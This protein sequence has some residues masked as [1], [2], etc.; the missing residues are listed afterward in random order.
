MAD[1]RAITVPGVDDSEIDPKLRVAHWDAIA[2]LDAGW[3]LR[4]LRYVPITGAGIV[5]ALTPTHRAVS[6]CSTDRNHGVHLL[7]IHIAKRLAAALADFGQANQHDHI[8]DLAW[9]VSR[10]PNA[11]ARPALP[12][13][14]DPIPDDKL[15]RQPP[16]LRAAFWLLAVLICD[17]GWTVTDLGDP[18]VHGGF[19]AAIPNDVTA[20]FPGGIPADG[21]AAT[22]LARLLPLLD[23]GSLH[24]LQHINKADLH[25]ARAA[26]HLANS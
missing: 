19:T 2:L 17:Y 6:I 14:R 25:R 7:H 12:A 3:Q 13:R 26:A 23:Q 22:A 10:H 1:H 21:S 24:Y 5:E 20:I 16:N 15:L 11:G 9:L 4:R 18:M 8:G